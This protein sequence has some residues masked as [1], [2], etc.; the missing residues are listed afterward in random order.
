M[1]DGSFFKLEY[2]LWDE[3]V[4]AKSLYGGA[5]PSENFVT[6]ETYDRDGSKKSK[7]LHPGYVK[8]A[9]TGGKKSTASS[10][11]KSSGSSSDDDDIEDPRKALRQL[12]NLSTRGQAELR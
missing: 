12:K 11:S 1:V 3:K 10:E 4:D 7:N 6:T 2:D 8:S 9:A 5:M